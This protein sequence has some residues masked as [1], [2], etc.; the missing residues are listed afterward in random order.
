[1]IRNLTKRIES[2]LMELRALGKQYGI[3]QRELKDCKD[4]H[5]CVFYLQESHKEN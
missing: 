4:L 5:E 3:S 2:D 1:M